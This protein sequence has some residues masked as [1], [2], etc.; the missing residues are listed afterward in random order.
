M[1]K[2]FHTYTLQVPN[3]VN[4][5]KEEESESRQTYN[6]GARRCFCTHVERRKRMRDK[7]RFWN[8]HIQNVYIAI[9]NDSTILTKIGNE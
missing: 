7:W 5:G 3:S 8:Y 6:I 1:L 2:A 4:F 9:D